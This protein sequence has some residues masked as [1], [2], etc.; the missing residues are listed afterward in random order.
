MQITAETITL[1]IIGPGPA[2]NDR[3]IWLPQLMIEAARQNTNVI[4]GRTF[5]QC[6]LEGPAVLLPVEGCRF[7]NCNMGDAMGDARNLLL[8]PL[9]PQK[10]TGTVAFK[11]CVFEACTF[12]RVGFTGSPDFL[13]ELEVM[14]GG[15]A[16]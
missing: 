1:P 13:R 16:S 11:N 9:G 6:L 5:T 2:H 3:H 7:N 15:A 14:L 4:E 8:S 12:A 10:V